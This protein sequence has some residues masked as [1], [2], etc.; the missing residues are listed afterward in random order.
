MCKKSEFNNV[1]PLY[2]VCDRLRLKKAPDRLKRIAKEADHDSFVILDR[3][4]QLI[5][6]REEARA[7]LRELKRRIEDGR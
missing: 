3:I 2:V 7:Q 6:E 1:N 4:D 5:A